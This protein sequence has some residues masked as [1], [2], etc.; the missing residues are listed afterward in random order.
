MEAPKGM[1]LWSAVGAPSNTI[2]RQR[3]E[4]Q[5]LLYLVDGQVNIPLNDIS[6]VEEVDTR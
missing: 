2:A 3:G 1:E 5:P 4:I 6:P